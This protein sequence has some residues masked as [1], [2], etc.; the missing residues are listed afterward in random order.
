[1]RLNV[2]FLVYNRGKLRMGTLD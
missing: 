2:I 1:M